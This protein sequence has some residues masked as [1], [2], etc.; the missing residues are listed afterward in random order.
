[1]GERVF[2]LL[3]QVAGRTGRGPLGG[4]VIIQT[5]SPQHYAVAAASAQD[6]EGFYQEEMTYREEQGLP[7]FGHLVHLVYLH[8]S[9]DR[10][11]QEA[12]RFGGVLKR[13]R[14]A[15][16][17]TNIDILGP[18][19]ANPPG[20][21]TSFSPGEDSYC[22]RLGRGGGPH[23]CCIREHIWIYTAINPDYNW[24]KA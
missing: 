12:L 10:C 2:Q 8:I 18:A 21:G 17:L 20:P 22:P 9:Q 13:Q 3:C 14:D 11:R 4:Q 1:A 5:Y 7:P 24:P 15:W 6:Y 19:P 23:I 16:G